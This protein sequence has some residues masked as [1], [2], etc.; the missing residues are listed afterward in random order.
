AD[1]INAIQR[2]LPNVSAD[3]N[4]NAPL[5][6]QSRLQF[7]Q[8][9]LTELATYDFSAVYMIDA[10]GRVLARAEQ[11]GAPAYLAPPP[12]MLRTRGADA[13]LRL[14]A[15]DM[16]RAVF[17]LSAYP[18]A[19]LYVVR[20]LGEGAMA[21]LRRAENSV[22]A[23]HEAERAR[24]RVQQVFVLS[25]VSVAMLVLIGA[26]WVG[27]AVANQIAT[28]V[29]RL[30]QAADLVAAGDL[31]ARVP[32]GREP[33]EIAVLSRAFNRMTS[34]LDAQ[35]E[36]LRRAGEEARGRRDFI[37]A[38]LS[39]VSAGVLGLDAHGA[40]SAANQPALVLLG[41]EGQDVLGRS[42]K[43]VAPE[44]CDIAERA[45]RTGQQA[46]GEVD[47]VRGA[48]TRRL[49]GRAAPGEEGGLVL[50]FDDITRLLSA[51]RNAAWRDVARRIAHEIKNP[52]T[53]IQLSAERLRRRYRKE[54]ASDLEI[55]DRCT[56]TIIRQVGDIGRMVDE[57]SSFARMPQPVF[58]PADLA[59]LVRETAFAQRIAYPDVAVEVGELTPAPISAD[60]RLLGQ[61]LANVLKN[62][63][64]AVAARAAQQPDPPG[65]IRVWIEEAAGRAS[66]MV[67]DNGVGLPAK[68]R[69]RLTEPY[70]T[71]RE[72]GTGLGL[73]IVKRILEEHGGELRLSDSAHPPGAR[74][75]LTLPLLARPALQAAE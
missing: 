1:Q 15:S 68:D 10:D 12:D 30:V 63:G 28:P 19:Y 44:L 49:R 2:R 43:E 3:L 17:R 73:A 25:Y 14:D 55:F 61:A 71:T 65:L 11:S 48:D 62:A 5:F 23:Y 27:L 22:L 31:S 45:R 64:E 38:V 47:V 33:A 7:A 29:A 50:T 69:E 21:K 54:I 60:A 52:L 32:T 70:M 36:A 40:V 9:M 37:E 26:V 34:D 56:D 66:V 46:E 6:A 13:P 59:E 51:Q 4:R 41:L 57:F 67:E 24:G 8:L 58:A 16:A 75:A 74:V 35:Q 18:D 72:K 20:P 42:L 53:P 39:G